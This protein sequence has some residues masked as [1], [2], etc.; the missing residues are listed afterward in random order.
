MRDLEKPLLQRALLDPRGFVPPAAAVVDYLLISQH[1]GALRAPVHQGFFAIRDTALQH[2]E[3]KPLVPAIVIRFAGGYL[4]IPVVAELKAAVRGLHLGNIGKGP[5]ARRPLVG[6]GGVFGGQ[7]E[8]V[9]AHGMQHVETAHP[10]VTRQGI[11]DS[12][13]A[14]VPDVQRARWIR[15]HLEHVKLRAARVLFRLVQFFARPFLIPLELDLLMV[16]RLFGH[17]EG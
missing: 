8:G 10:L 13:V 2:F 14:H 6:D 17:V 5:F 3:K 16:V 7:P 4:A 12:V 11:T 9:P 1:R 15:Q